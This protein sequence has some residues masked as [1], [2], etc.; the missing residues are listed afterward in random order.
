MQNTK[1]LTAILALTAMFLATSCGTQKPE[2]SVESL[3]PV[4]SSESPIPS[5]EPV[6]SETPVSSEEPT[7][8]EEPTSSEEPVSSEE[9]IIIDVTDISL[10]VAEETIGIGESL[11]LTA[12]VLPADAT[13]PTVSW[14]SSDESVATVVD[15]VVTGIAAG[16]A[17]IKAKAGEKEASATIIV[18]NFE[19]ENWTPL[20]N[21][22]AYYY[23][24]GK[25]INNN[26]E[27]IKDGGAHW[28]DDETNFNAYKTKQ[29]KNYKLSVEFKG[30]YAGNVD[31]E[32]YAGLLAWYKDPQNYVVIA[33][34]WA[35][36]DRPHEIRSI[37]A[38]TM[39]N[40]VETTSDFWT[41][42]C[43][44]A[45]ADGLKLEVTKAGEDFSY[46]VTTEGH[47]IASPKTKGSFKVAAA[48]TD[49]ATVGIVGANDA[50]VY[51]NFSAEAIEISNI[52]TY[53]NVVSETENYVLNLNK[54]DSTYQLI[55]NVDGTATT[56]VGTYAANGRNLT[57]TASDSTISHVKV[58]DNTS[59]FVFYTPEE[60][61]YINSVVVEAGQNTTIKENMKGDY[62]FTYSYLGTITDSGH[63][64]QAGFNA[65]YVDENN[66]LD[67]Y[68][69]WSIGDRP[70]EIRCVQMTG[71]IDG[72][73][74]GW[75]DMWC[76]G[77]NLLPGDGGTLT[78]TKT[79]NSFSAKFVSGS[80]SNEKTA[81]FAGLDTS[82]A[83]SMKFYSLGDTFTYYNYSFDE[84]GLYDVTGT[85]TLNSL[86][87]VLASGE[88]AI[89]K[90]SSTDN[91]S[92]SFDYRGLCAQPG[93]SAKLGFHPWYV[94][95]NNHLDFY[96]EW[97][98]AGRP[99]DIRCIQMTGVVGGTN[100]GWNDVWCDG[101]NALPA[102]GGTFTITKSGNTFTVKVVAGSFS[103]EDSRTFSGIDTSIVFKRGFYSEGDT[104][105]L[106]NIVY[107]VA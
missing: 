52:V 63:A 42:N 37:F 53:N 40:G 65:W 9:P 1:S 46:H 87:Y 100:V 29:G 14:T 13:D 39:I 48:N 85:P 60:Q 4:T 5:E 30:T 50:F 104:F 102:D 93:V 33:A 6:S 70:H 45:N 79:G 27:D 94:D 44:V 58:Y 90:A 41:D 11:T 78:F 31:N 28:I 22:K 19:D 25:I 59:T 86:N 72:E 73:R 89:T 71:F 8:S 74:V 77:S 56:T 84:S 26:T 32:N 75:N 101:S 17:T 51:E 61:T 82:L 38:V 24:N 83:Y 43:G 35:N 23:E 68:V 98:D 10:D 69:E 95:E 2:T 7:P 21:T 76:D 103:K 55:H 66:Y 12:T 64:V 80:Y 20:G 91:Y 18:R 97:G 99:N 81:T 36:W 49:E 67:F 106:K 92:I 57:L 34:R 105:T 3:E 107:T 47:D 16:T 54:D 62:S 96:L 88:K 15:G